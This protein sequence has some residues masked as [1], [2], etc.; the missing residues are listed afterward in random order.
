[1]GEDPSQAVTTPAGAPHTAPARGSPALA[2]P[3]QAAPPRTGPP[4]TGPPRNFGGGGADVDAGWPGA[5]DGRGAGPPAV[6]V[7]VLVRAQARA[8]AATAAVV[9]AVLAGLPLL[10][11]IAPALG[12]ARLCGLPLLWFVPVLAVHPVWIALAAWH[13]RRAERAE[14]AFSLAAGRR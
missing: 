14:R 1:M 7:R 9:A 4:R 12:R 3:V 13:V 10:P 6:L 5:K 2:G 11:L 8:A